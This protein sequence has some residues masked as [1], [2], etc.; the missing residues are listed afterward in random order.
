MQKKEVKREEKKKI[1]FTTGKRKKAIARARIKSGTGKVIINSMALDTITDDMVRMRI[2]EPLALVGD[3]WKNYDISVNIKG[4]G[5]MGQAEAAKQAIARGL[6]QLFG[7]ETKKR[8]LNYDRNLLIY[9]PR[10]T[11]PHKPSR[12]S[13]GPRRHKQRSKR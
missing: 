2:Q 7:Q 4:G 10:R 1:I 3:G 9:D 13:K 6:V 8:F 5:I 11:E 12:S